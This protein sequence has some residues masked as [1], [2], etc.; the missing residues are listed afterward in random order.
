MP[1]HLLHTAPSRV[2]VSWTA[3]RRQHTTHS[4]PWSVSLAPRLA[5]LPLGEDGLCCPAQAD[6]VSALYARTCSRVMS[7]LECSLRSPVSLKAHGFCVCASHDEAA[8]QNRYDTTV[9]VHLHALRLVCLLERQAGSCCSSCAEAGRVEQLQPCQDQDVASSP[10]CRAWIQSRH[11]SI[12]HGGLTCAE[13]SAA[14]HC[15]KT[16]SGC[17]QTGRS[18]REAASRKGGSAKE[19]AVERSVGRLSR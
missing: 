6:A 4:R 11:V 2:S 10:L 13:S 19:A 17:F 9:V 5:A 14:R 15:E 16:T 3:C 7:V 12:N 18:C 1:R 8:S